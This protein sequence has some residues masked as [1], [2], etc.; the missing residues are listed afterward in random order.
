MKVNFN[1]TEPLRSLLETTAKV[2]FPYP[3]S[4]KQLEDVLKEECYKIPLGA[5]RNLYGPIPRAAT[6]LIAKGCPTP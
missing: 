6:V 5:V 1:I 4:L 2:R 3:T